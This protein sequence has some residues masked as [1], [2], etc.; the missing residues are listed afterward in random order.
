[1]SPKQAQW[2]LADCNPLPCMLAVCTSV[3]APG[4]TSHSNQHLWNVLK[5]FRGDQHKCGSLSSIGRL[6]VLVNQ[7]KPTQEESSGLG[8]PTSVSAVHCRKGSS[9][10]RS[11]L[12][13]LCR[14]HLM[15]R[16]P[17]FPFQRAGSTACCIAPA[18]H[19]HYLP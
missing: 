9:A 10:Y 2:H 18:V 6:K 17:S 14:A 3:F 16:G 4:I 5:L 13:P 7:P 11:G 1:M 8:N 15:V 19:A 12:P